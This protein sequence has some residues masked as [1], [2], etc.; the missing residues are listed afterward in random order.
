MT[1]ANG[2]CWHISE[3][4]FATCTVRKPLESGN[5]AYGDEIGILL[6]GGD[7][8]ARVSFHPARDSNTPFELLPVRRATLRSSSFGW[9]ATLSKGQATSFTRADLFGRLRVTLRLL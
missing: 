6:C 5:G 4:R 2:C 1:D 9:Q 3:E 8:A 7:S